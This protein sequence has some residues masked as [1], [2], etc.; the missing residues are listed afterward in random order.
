MSVRASSSLTSKRAR[1]ETFATIPL[2]W[3]GTCLDREEPP[4]PIPVSS[5]WEARRN[6]SQHT[7]C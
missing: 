3:F 6:F 2:H 1:G 7:L 4:S 5:Q